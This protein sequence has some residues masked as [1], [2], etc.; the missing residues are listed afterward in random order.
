MTFFFV[1]QIH[2]KKTLFGL[3]FNKGN[4]TKENPTAFQKV[5]VGEVVNNPYKL[6]VRN[7]IQFYKQESKRLNYYGYIRYY[8]HDVSRVFSLIS[9]Y[10]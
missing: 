4:I 10:N 6:S 9:Y 3:W 1:F 8:R 2:F 7:W 5:F